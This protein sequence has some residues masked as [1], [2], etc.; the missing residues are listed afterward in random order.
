MRHWKLKVLKVQEFFPFFIFQNKTCLER[1]NAVSKFLSWFASGSFRSLLSRHGSAFTLFPTEHGMRKMQCRKNLNCIFHQTRFCTNSF[2]LNGAGTCCCVWQM[3]HR[4]T[5]DQ[6]QQLSWLVVDQE[7]F[8]NNWCLT[9]WQC[10][11]T[12]LNKDW[13]LRQINWPE[14]M[15]GFIYEINILLLLHFCFCLNVFAI[16][17]FLLSL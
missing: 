14:T 1:N 9:F 15:D 6:L 2:C 7:L 5:F 11:Y 13:D 4:M 12:C 17:I 8:E 3:L 16:S 10:W